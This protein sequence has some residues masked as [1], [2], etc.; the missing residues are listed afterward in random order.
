MVSKVKVW[1][2]L[3]WVPGGEARRYSKRHPKREPG[4]MD[5][6]MPMGKKENLVLNLYSRAAPKLREDGIEKTQAI[7]GLSLHSMGM[8]KLI[9]GGM[10]QLLG[11]PKIT[12]SNLQHH[13]RNMM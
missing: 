3:D 8:S 6:T 10:E 12:N 13:G 2:P 9:A 7:S 1:H 5:N 4:G 11:V